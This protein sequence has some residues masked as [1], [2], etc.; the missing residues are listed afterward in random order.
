MSGTAQVQQRERRVCVKSNELNHWSPAP[1][2]LSLCWVRPWTGDGPERQ[3]VHVIHTHT[4]GREAVRLFWQTECVCD[5]VSMALALAA[6]C[7]VWAGLSRLTGQWWTHSGMMTS[8]GPT[9]GLY[10]KPGSVVCLC[11][12]ETLSLSLS[13]IDGS[14]T[15][16][17]PLVS[18]M[19]FAPEQ[20]DPQAAVPSVDEL[21]LGLLS[22]SF[23]CW[24]QQPWSRP[25]SQRPTQPC[26]QTP[27]EWTCVSD[28]MLQCWMAAPICLFKLVSDCFSVL[29]VIW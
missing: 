5:G 1:F 20:Q 3:T 11:A 26:S 28:V 25:E 7:E 18:S 9:A 14:G 29:S 6:V 13:L 22:L 21:S 16:C 24:N 2:H 19:L 10:G 8:T 27:G 17:S 12:S 4:Q 15:D 23:P